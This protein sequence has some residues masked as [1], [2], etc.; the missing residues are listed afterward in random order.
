MPRK[1]FEAD[2]GRQT[3]TTSAYLQVGKGLQLG[4]VVLE[5]EGVVIRRRNAR[6]IIRHLDQPQAVV[7][8]PHLRKK[9]DASSVGM[10]GLSRFA[11]CYWHLLSC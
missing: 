2:S 7:F 10:P 9:Q 1:H 5:R 3:V 6:A 8:H 11:S 4:R